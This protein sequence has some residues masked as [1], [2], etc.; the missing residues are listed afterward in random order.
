MFQSIAKI[1]RQGGMS[2]TSLATT[3]LIV[4]FLATAAVKIGPAY[5][6]N[7]TVKS[8]LE[9]IQA[10]YRGKDLQDIS[11]KEIR[12]KL[13]KYFQVNRVEGPAAASIE[14]VREKLKVIVT[15]NYEVRNNFMGNVDVVLVFENEVDLTK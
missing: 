2:M 8:A 4:G 6:S 10:D 12:T 1:Q 15:A 9:S 14:I 13:D 5:L 3:L 11:N 7:N